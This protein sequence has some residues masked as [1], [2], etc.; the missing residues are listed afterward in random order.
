VSSAEVVVRHVVSVLTIWGRE[1][2]LAELQS[3]KEV[4]ERNGFS[5]FEL[6]SIVPDLVKG[7]GNI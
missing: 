3:D 7:L 4:I 5:K 2:S 6:K 1:N